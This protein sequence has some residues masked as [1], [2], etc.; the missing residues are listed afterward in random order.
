MM[1]HVRFDG[2]NQDGHVAEAATPDTFVGELAEP[3]F[4]KIHPG[5]GRGRKVEMEPRMAFHPGVD[6]RMFVR[7]IIVDDQVQGQGARRLGVDALEEPDKLLMPV[8]RHAIP[9]DF[10]IEHAQGRKEG[11]GAIALVVVGLSSRNPR[12]QGEQGLRAVEG[13]NLALLVDAQHQGFVGR[14]E[15]EAHDILELLDEVCVATELEGLDQVGLQVVPLPDP[16]DGG[17]AQA[18]GPRHTART[19]M[20]RLG[21]GRVQGGFDHG[22]HLAD[23]DP[24]QAPW[25][26]RILF[27]SQHAQGQKPL[28]PQLDG[29]PRDPPPVRD[30]LAQHPVGRQPNDLRPLHQ[31]Q[32]Q[33]A[34]TGPRRQGRTLLGGQHAGGCGAAHGAAS[35]TALEYTTSYL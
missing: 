35:Y 32:G 2:R 34:R 30:L 5:T 31:S 25:P 18:L 4:D 23:R 3:P 29:R 11:R 26:R 22:P 12:P 15:V 28:P 20:R 13:L 8:T 7:P 14:I 19:P 24:R 1:R 9:D 17:F 16:T 10:A 27:Q 21:R 6:P 33:A